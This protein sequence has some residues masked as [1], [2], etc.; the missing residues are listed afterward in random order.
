V[1]QRDQALGRI[2]PTWHQ[3]QNAEADAMLQAVKWAA[4]CRDGSINEFVPGSEAVRLEVNDLK[5]NLLCFPEA[6][7]SFPETHA[8]TQNR[9][10]QFMSESAK[11]PM[12]AEA[13]YNAANISFVQRSQGMTELYIPQVASLEKQE[14]E[15]EV[16]LKNKPVPNPKIVQAEQLIAQ[17]KSSPLVDQTQ[18][19]QAETELQQLTQ[20][21]PL[22][23]SIPIDADTE[24]N[25]TEAFTCWKYLNS[26][27]GRAAKKNNNE[28]YTNVKLHFM[29]HR[30]AAQA[31]AA[32]GGAAGK[33]PSVSISYKDAAA[34]DPSA[35]SQ[36]LQKAGIQ[37]KPVAQLP[38]RA[39]GPAGPQVPPGAPIQ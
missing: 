33:P 39:P 29:D 24:D 8:Q 1:I 7:E 18:L 5:S 6:D 14:G 3:I 38:A 31:N 23:T 17:L 9:L 32:G 34:N 20:T 15:I 30:D 10:T 36:I 19:V 35:G 2:G 4:R 26:P 21:K 27:E 22:V 11:N 25:G 28:G 12:L 37:S 16:L 13:L